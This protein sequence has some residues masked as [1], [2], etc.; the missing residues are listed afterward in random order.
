VERGDVPG[1]RVGDGGPAAGRGDGM[2]G[3]CTVLSRSG[4]EAAVRLLEALA[5]SGVTTADAEELTGASAGPLD[6][7]G[8]LPWDFIATA[9][10]RATLRRA[11]DAMITR[12]GEG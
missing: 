10:P 9:H 8:P 5:G 6:P 2:A 1:V 3:V 11:F 4:G 7:D 12:L